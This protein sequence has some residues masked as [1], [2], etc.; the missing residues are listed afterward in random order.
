MRR[1]IKCL[2]IFT[3]LPYSLSNLLKSLISISIIKAR[4]HELFIDIKIVRRG[5]CPGADG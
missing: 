1:F 3:T 4:A 5:P 2:I